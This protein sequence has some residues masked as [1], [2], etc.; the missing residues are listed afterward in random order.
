[1]KKGEII[2]T[3]SIAEELGEEKIKSFINFALHYIADIEIPVKR[4]TFVEFRKGMIN[5]SPIGRS[6]SQ[7]ERDAFFELDKEQG[8]R[9]TFLAKLTENFS[10]S[11][12]LQFAIGGQISLDCFPKGWDKTKCLQYLEEFETIHF[13]GDMVDKGG[14]DHEIYESERTIG[15]RVTNPE[16]TMNQLKEFI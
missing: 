1:M 15:H 11:H 13:F 7:T 12:G 14:N 16:D 2:A 10:E 8:I 6:C 3:S 4:G 9:R 5:I